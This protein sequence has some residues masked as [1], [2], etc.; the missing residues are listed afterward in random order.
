[1]IVK[2]LLEI[3][4]VLG[5]ISAK[6]LDGGIDLKSFGKI[7]KLAGK[8]INLHAALLKAEKKGDLEKMTQ[9]RAD[10]ELLSNQFDVAISESKTI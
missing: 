10:G 1:M 6:L 9:I 2:P 7:D 5:K 3:A 4:D 8:L